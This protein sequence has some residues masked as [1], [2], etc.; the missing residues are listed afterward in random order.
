MIGFELICT[1]TFGSKEES[2]FSPKG[3]KPRGS[4]CWLSSSV[5]RRTEFTLQIHATVY[6]DRGG[7]PWLSYKSQNLSPC[8][9]AD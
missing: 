2:L 7:F 6:K 4:P 3:K 5:G 1:E 8:V 9:N